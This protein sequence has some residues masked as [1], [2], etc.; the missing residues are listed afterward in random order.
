MNQNSVWKSTRSCK[1][2]W[3]FLLQS[4]LIAG[5]LPTLNFATELND[6]YVEIGL[7][8]LT[9]SKVL[10]RLL[11]FYFRLSSKTNHNVPTRN[12]ILEKSRASD[13]SFPLLLK[14][15]MKAPVPSLD[16]K[17]NKQAHAGR[18]K[19]RHITGRQKSRS[20]AILILIM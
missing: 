17:G 6:L 13:F 10:P 9:E 20:S 2:S 8:I 14:P 12:F 5:S 3:R 1:A 16:S 7:R 19:I 15:M 18:Y 4:P 11:M